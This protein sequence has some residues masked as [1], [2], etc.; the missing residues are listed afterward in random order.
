MNQRSF[1]LFGIMGPIVSYVSIAISI[2]L[3]PWF[4]W[5]KNALSD[6]G[7]ATESRVSPIF[8]LGLLLGGFFILIYANSVFSKHSKYTSVCMGVS[9]FSLQLVARFNETYGYLHFLVSV[10]FFLSLGLLAIVYTFENKFY[11]G[12]LP[13]S[14]GLISWVTYGRLYNSGIAVPETISSLAVVIL[15]LYSAIRIYLGKDKLNES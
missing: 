5:Q 6:L 2:L 12:I 15:I 10:L 7:H 13:F 3:S 4:S 11:F 14:I 8:N 1:T 9:A